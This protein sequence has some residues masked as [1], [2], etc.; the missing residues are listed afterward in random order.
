MFR[1]DGENFLGCNLLDSRSLLKTEFISSFLFTPEVE[2]GVF[3]V[4]SRVSSKSVL[5][6]PT[7]IFRKKQ[8]WKGWQAIIT[9][10][11]DRHIWPTYGIPLPLWLYISGASSDRK[12]HTV[13]FSG[14]SL[15]VFYIL[16][17]GT[18]WVQGYNGRPRSSLYIK[19]SNISWYS[20]YQWLM[21]V[22]LLLASHFESSSPSVELTRKV[23]QWQSWNC[24]HLLS[25]NMNRS[26][27]FQVFHISKQFLG[28]SLVLILIK[29]QIGWEQNLVH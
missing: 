11:T 13:M 14:Y 5:L 7:D 2:L 19:W 18:V 22:L 21:L 15:Q 27:G 10:M 26:L 29:F 12:S 17:R 4:F 8:I 9:K 24:L 20:S 16:Y 3:D 6:F 28:L 25:P 23:F 1:W